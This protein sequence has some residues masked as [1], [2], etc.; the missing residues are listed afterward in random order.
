MPPCASQVA[1]LLAGEYTGEEVASVPLKS[2]QE[3]AAVLNALLDVHEPQA[4]S[5]VSAL[6]AQ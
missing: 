5:H 2:P 3:L 4:Q 1:N 6:T